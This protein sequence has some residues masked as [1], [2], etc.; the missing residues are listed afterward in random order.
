MFFL[1]LV[2]PHLHAAF[3]VPAIPVFVFQLMSYM[4]SHG[5]HSL[6]WYFSIFIFIFIFILIHTIFDF[7]TTTTRYIFV[8]R[9]HLLLFLLLIVFI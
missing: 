3:N 1:Y 2:P 4:Y 5:A 9:F 7:Y 8:I 6:T